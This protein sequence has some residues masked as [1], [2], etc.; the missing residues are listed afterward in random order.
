MIHAV[1]KA[2]KAAA[3]TDA[4]Q[5]AARQAFVTAI[6]AANLTLFKA[7]KAAKVQLRATLAEIKRTAPLSVVSPA[8]NNCLH[9]FGMQGFG[10]GES[11]HRL[12]W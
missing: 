4:E 11:G 10:F 5:A 7:I 8:A 6:R 1:Y 2:E 12:R 3:T 9:G